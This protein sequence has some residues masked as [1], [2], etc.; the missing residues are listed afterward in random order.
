MRY[1]KKLTIK[2]YGDAFF[3]FLK[4]NM[5]M[6]FVNEFFELVFLMHAAVLHAYLLLYFCM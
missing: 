2:K 5:G 6:P 1:I 3:F 4:E